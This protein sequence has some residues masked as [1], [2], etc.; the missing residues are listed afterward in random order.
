MTRLTP[1]YSANRT[2]REYT[3]QHYLP[4]ATSY[5]LRLTNKGAIGRQMVEWHHALEKEW[6]AIRFGKMK[7]GTSREQ[8]TFEV[9]A[10]LNNLDPNAARVE[11]YADGVNGGG[12]VRQEMKR[13]QQLACASGGY[14][15]R[16]RVPATRPADPDS[17]LWTAL[18]EMDHDGV[19][20]LPVMTG[21]QVVGT[22]GCEDVITFL[23]TVQEL[24]T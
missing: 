11:L 6:P 23:R 19:S 14:W 3:E 12:P 7:V 21:K 1:R 10:Y 20:Q 5:H 22:L 4:A 24:G 17:G 16:A 15:Y 18:Q 9:Q 13:V 8:H 2:V